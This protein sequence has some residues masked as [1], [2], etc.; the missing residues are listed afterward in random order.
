MDTSISTAERWS[1]SV[2]VFT[3]S[4]YLLMSSG[5]GLACPRIFA[6]PP[7]QV[8]FH[9]LVSSLPRSQGLAYIVLPFVFILFDYRFFVTIPM[10]WLLPA[11]L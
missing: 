4:G 11:V 9:F 2:L 6:A 5:S 8:V 1:D 7:A 3:P 10:H